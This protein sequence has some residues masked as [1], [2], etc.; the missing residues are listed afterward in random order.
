MSS[1]LNVTEVLKARKIEVFFNGD[2]I[3]DVEKINYHDYVSPEARYG[4][5]P[6]L[7]EM[8]IPVCV[9]KSGLRYFLALLLR[10]GHRMRDQRRARRRRRHMRRRRMR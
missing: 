3:G 1:V 7:C 9:D 6:H 4:T 5:T 8:T 2:L 10:G